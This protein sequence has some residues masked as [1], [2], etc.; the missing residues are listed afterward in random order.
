[1]PFFTFSWYPEGKLG[2]LNVSPRKSPV[3]LP[4]GLHWISCHS[5]TVLKLPKAPNNLKLLDRIPKREG[6]V[7]WEDKKSFMHTSCCHTVHL[8]Q[9]DDEVHAARAFLGSRSWLLKANRLC[10]SAALHT[11]AEVPARMA[12]NRVTANKN[13]DPNRPICA[14]LILPPMASI[15]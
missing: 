7:L 5:Y 8:Q 1:M 15:A 11:A 3:T 4:L 9:S 13:A 10:L 12:A 14:P 6:D 2:A